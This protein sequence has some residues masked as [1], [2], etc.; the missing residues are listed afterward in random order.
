MLRILLSHSLFGILVLNN[1]LAMHVFFFIA[2]FANT[3][4]CFFYLQII[5]LLQDPS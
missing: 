1:D 3:V 4:N 5:M 2:N